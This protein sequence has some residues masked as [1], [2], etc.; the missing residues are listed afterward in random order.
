MIASVRSLVY[1]CVPPA[2]IRLANR[3][4]DM[5]RPAHF[6]FVGYTWSDRLPARGWEAEGVKQNRE[7]TWNPFVSSLSRTTLLGISEEDLRFPRAVNTN[8]Q[9]LYLSYGYCLGLACR[10]SSKAMVLDWGGSTGNYYLVSKQLL[11]EVDFTYRCAELPAACAIGRT[12]LPAVVFDEDESWKKLRFDFVFS[13]SALQ[14][15]DDWRPTVDALVQSSKRYLYITRMPF[16][17]T[18]RSF[19]AIQRV[20][21]YRTEYLGW[22]LNRSEF[23]Q[24]IEGRGMRLVRQ[25]VNHAG[26][27]I[28]GAPEPNLYMGFLFEK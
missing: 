10:H 24:F 7:R 22:V 28:R 6:E 18:A 12:L 4:L 27:R 1:D 15:L 14:Y 16:V 5:V 23:V 26:P 19:V 3:I 9:S 21:S 11:P 13:S 20:K 8:L 17:I 25:F 2:A